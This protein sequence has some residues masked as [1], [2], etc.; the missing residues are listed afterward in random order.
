MPAKPAK[1]TPAVRC[2]AACK[3]KRRKLA[4]AYATAAK[5]EGPQRS[6]HTISSNTS[7]NT[8][9]S[10]LIANKDN[11]NAYNRVYIPPAN[12]EEEK[13]SSS[14]DNSVNSSTSDSTNKGED[15]GIY[16]RSKG[17]LYYKG[18]AAAAAAKA[19]DTAAAEPTKPANAAAVPA[20]A[21]NT[22][23]PAKA[24]AAK[25]ASAATATAAVVDD[26]DNTVPPIVFTSS[27][28]I[29][30][31]AKAKAKAKEEEEEGE[32]EEDKEVV[33]EEKDIGDRGKKDKA[34][35]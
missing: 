35:S 30:L 24:A 34:K 32:K 26:I 20:T 9:N 28:Y 14:N 1:I 2:T 12:I 10:G 25:P 7:R 18:T 19:A 5:K 13:G 22:A 4:K 16:K 29:A 15:S 21:A 27:A 11:N 33:K 31:Y 6:K 8:T 23:V 17:A 3:A